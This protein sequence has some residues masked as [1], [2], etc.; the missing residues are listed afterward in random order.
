[1]FLEWEKADRGTTSQK[2]QNLNINIKTTS[3]EVRLKSADADEVSSAPLAGDPNERI[4]TPRFSTTVHQLRA[5]VQATLNSRG[6][7]SSKLLF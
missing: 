6:N 7:F 1:M 3:N 5:G 4:L 2:K